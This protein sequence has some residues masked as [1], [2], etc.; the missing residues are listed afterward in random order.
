LR[1]FLYLAGPAMHNDEMSP[2]SILAFTKQ[3]RRLIA[4]LF[5]CHVT[6]G[7]LVILLW[8]LGHL[9]PV[10]GPL[11]AAGFAAAQVYAAAQLI[12][13]ALLLHPEQRSRS[14]YL[15]WAAVLILT[16]WLVNLVPVSPAGAPVLPAIQSALLLLVATIIGAAM[17]RYVRRLWEIVP[18][19][20]VIT[21]ADFASWLVGPTSG[22]VQQVEHYYRT[23]E[24]PPPLV[25]MILV[26]L[27]FPGQAGLLPVFG[28][29]DWI[30]VVFFAITA[31]HFDVNDNLIGAHGETL[32]RRGRIGGYLPVSVLALFV[33]LLLAQLTGE[34]VPAL[35][36]IAAI[37]LLWYGV[38]HAMLKVFR[39]GS[40]Q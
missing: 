6:W 38:R 36:F 18:I 12:L 15:F 28:V 37:M 3:N 26:K 11:W 17:A 7:A 1:L 13:P 35:P 10:S 8:A 23:F 30:M 24:G 39:K 29:S 34:F 14:F 20:I 19:C 2:I 21:A 16:I 33:A 4:L 27:A 25:D 40:G 9:F 5:G 32:A 22:F 31:R